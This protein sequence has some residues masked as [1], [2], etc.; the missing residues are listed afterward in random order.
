MDCILH[1]TRSS[2]RHLSLDKSIGWSSGVE[3]VDALVIEGVTCKEWSN[4]GVI[5]TFVSN[6]FVTKWRISWTCFREKGD[7]GEGKSWGEDKV[8]GIVKEVSNGS[9]D[10]ME[11]VISFESSLKDGNIKASSICETGK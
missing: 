11:D 8:G 9:G 2:I 1:K 7:D 5:L 6:V 10:G 4:L 3:D